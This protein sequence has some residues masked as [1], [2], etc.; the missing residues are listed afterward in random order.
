MSGETSTHTI[1][2]CS[3]HRGAH[4]PGR[5]AHSHT[6]C[7]K[8]YPVTIRTRIQHYGHLQLPVCLYGPP[9]AAVCSVLMMKQRVVVVM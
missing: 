2:M 8:P 5:R 1:G 6:L 7:P 4:C 9:I 3:N